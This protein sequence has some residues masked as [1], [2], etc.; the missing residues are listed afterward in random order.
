MSSTAHADR[1]TQLESLWEHD[2]I[3]IIAV[4][5]AIYIVYALIGLILG[6]S[7][8][9]IINTLRRMTYL[10]AVYGMVTLALNLHWGYTGLFNIG[11]AGFMAIGLYVTMML[12]KPVDPGGAAQYSGLGLPMPIAIIGGVVAAG[13]AGLV[14]A[15]PALRL[16]ADYFAITTIAFAEIVRLGVTSDALQ[17]FTILGA[18]L[19][20]GGG[21]GLIRNYDDPMNVIFQLEIFSSFVNLTN[22]LFGF[23][24]TQARALAYSI[25]LVIVLAGIY[26]LIQRTSRS[27]FGRVLKAI[28]EDEEAAQSLGKNTN[29]FKIKV[30]V[31][32]CALMGLA[33][34]LWRFRRTGVTP[35]AF[36]PHVTFYIWIAL[37]IGG[38]GSNTGS[39]L[40]SGL[41]VAVL[42]EGPQY[43]RRV[44][45]QLVAVG[46]APNTF[47]G[48]VGP[49]LSANPVPLVR[50]T[51]A[52]FLTLQF[53]IMGVA[54]ILLMQRRPDG[55]LGH[56]EETAAAIPLGARPSAAGGGSGGGGGGGGGGG[57]GSDSGFAHSQTRDQHDDSDQQTDGGIDAD[58]ARTQ[59]GTSESSNESSGSTDQ[60]DDSVTDGETQ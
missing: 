11:V 48:A 60:T 17:Q 31:L 3:K 47:A 53:V 46:D 34:I 54:L 52:E 15:L 39:I 36:R 16:R 33:G 28:R 2:A 42:F 9:G 12:A 27:P 43:L 35:E 6:Y 58:G 59:A 23:G 49:L 44:I 51:F 30:F 1:R 56:R 10:I 13:L 26:W 55:L 50:Y 20:T 22:S 29:M 38:A 37:I 4:I 57:N 21:R 32:G 45:D 5:G 18:E 25:V 19:G 8:D 24:P 7:L 41:F 14:V 40:G